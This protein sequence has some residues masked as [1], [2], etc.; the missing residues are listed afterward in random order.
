MHM[1]KYKCEMQKNPESLDICMC[2]S[3]DY[4]NE[5]FSQLIQLEELIKTLYKAHK[6]ALFYQL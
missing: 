2:S 5:V 1:F 3:L 4:M 6:Y